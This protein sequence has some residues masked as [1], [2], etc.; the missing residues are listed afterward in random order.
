MLYNE[1]T[2]QWI[3]IVFVYNEYVIYYLLCNILILFYKILVHIEIFSLQSNYKL[4][5]QEKADWKKIR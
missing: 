2:V 1:Y 3:C 5:P 4:G